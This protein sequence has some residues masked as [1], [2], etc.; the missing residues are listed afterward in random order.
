MY[1]FYLKFSAV[2][3]ISYS[4]VPIVIDL[5]DLKVCFL[6]SYFTETPLY[7]IFSISVY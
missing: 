2:I 4:I 5:N 1:N 6:S 3:D 7:K